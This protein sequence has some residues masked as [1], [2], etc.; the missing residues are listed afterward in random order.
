VVRGAIGALIFLV[1]L[2]VL[3]GYPF[4]GALGLAA[5]MLALYI[6]LGYYLDRF[7]WRRRQRS[8]HRQRQADG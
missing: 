4:A 8:L 3:F 7:F 6:P 2:M 5:I 1:L